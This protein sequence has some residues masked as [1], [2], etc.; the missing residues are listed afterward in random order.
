MAAMRNILSIAVTSVASPCS[1]RFVLLLGINWVSLSYRWTTIDSNNC[2]FL[3]AG[4]VNKNQ[5]TANRVLGLV[6]WL[7]FGVVKQYSYNPATP[8]FFCY[9]KGSLERSEICEL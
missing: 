9:S 4:A 7:T 2:V 1:C 8:R 6:G 5:I 3:G